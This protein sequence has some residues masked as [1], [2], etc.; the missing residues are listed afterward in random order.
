MARLG[1]YHVVVIRWTEPGG[2]ERCQVHATRMWE[3]A[4]GPPLGPGVSEALS[5]AIG[6]AGR[7][8]APYINCIGGSLTV[9]DADR[10]KHL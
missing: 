7:S 2:R 3:S 6:S 10:R 4:D 5:A 8:G 9:W 1:V